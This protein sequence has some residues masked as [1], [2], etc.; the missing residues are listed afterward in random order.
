MR[1]LALSQKTPVTL[2]LACPF[3]C[4]LRCLLLVRCAVVDSSRRR[5]LEISADLAKKVAAGGVVSLPFLASMAK[6]ASADN[7]LHKGKGHCF[8]RGTRILT[9][10]GEVPVEKLTIGTLVETLNGPM[11]VKWIGHQSF[12]KD[13]PSW[14]WNMAPIRVARSALGDQNPRRDLFLSPGHSLFIDGFLIPVEWLVNGRSIEPAAMDGQDVI[15]YFHVELE[16]HEVVFAEGTPAETFLVSADR[17]DFVNFMEYE[18]VYGADERPAMKPFAPIINY[19][20]SRGEVE[21][22]LR[23]AVSPVLDIRDPSQR[24]RDRIAT[25]AELVVT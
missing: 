22:L 13:D 17:E 19:R 8:L 6:R 20:G 24:A 16:T 3:E 25:R 5:F 10:E 21:R 4:L 15:D 23:L 9:P 12:R 7:G 11:P 18:R 14:H 1:R 2:F